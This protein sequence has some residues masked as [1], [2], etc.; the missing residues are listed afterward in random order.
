MCMSMYLSTSALGDQRCE[1]PWSSRQGS[2]QLS[3]RV[4]GT[5]VW[6]FWKATP[7]FNLW[8][9][10][11]VPK[12]VFLFLFGRYCCL[13]CWFGFWWGEEGIFQKSEIIIT[14]VHRPLILKALRKTCN[15]IYKKIHD[16]SLREHQTTSKFGSHASQ[17]FVKT[18]HGHGCPASVLLFYQQD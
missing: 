2:F 13:V 17:P 1:I 18:E 10:A 11:P 15:T 9:I 4:L 7:V 8:D 5:E 3:T 6:S 14:Y 16:L 12:P